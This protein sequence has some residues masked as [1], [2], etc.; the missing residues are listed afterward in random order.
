VR[1]NP[2]LPILQARARLHERLGDPFNRRATT[3]AMNLKAIVRAPGD[4]NLLAT[5]GGPPIANDD[6]IYDEVGGGDL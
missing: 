6:L 4:D 1:R 3:V 5:D 2:R